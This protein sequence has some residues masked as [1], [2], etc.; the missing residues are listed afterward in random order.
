MMFLTGCGLPESAVDPET[1]EVVEQLAEATNPVISV[2]GASPIPEQAQPDDPGRNEGV[3]E[4]D[5][6]AKAEALSRGQL[7]QAFR[8]TPPEKKLPKA[9]PSSPAGGGVGPS[10]KGGVTP[11]NPDP[12]AE[13]DRFLERMEQANI[14]F[15]TPETMTRGVS[16]TFQL[17]LHPTLSKEELESRLAK[18]TGIDSAEVRIAPIMQA[19]LKGAGFT[20][21]AVSPDT[22]PIGRSEPTE[23]TWDVMPDQPGRQRLFLT[24]N[25]VFSSHGAEQ[26]RLIKSFDREIE[27]RVT[28]GEKALRVARATAA[29]TLPVILFGVGYTLYRRRTRTKIHDNQTLKVPRP[30]DLADQATVTVA[31]V[32]KP[33]FAN[34]Q[35]GHM[36]LGRYRVVKSLGAGGTAMVYRCRD[37][38]SGIDVAVKGI[39]PELAGNAPEM[40]EFRKNFQL[41]EKLHHPQIAASKTLEWDAEINAFYLIMEFVDGRTLR[42][43]FQEA[44][45]SM[46]SDEFF[47]LFGQVAAALDYAHGEG[48]M[49]RDIKPDNIMVTSEGKVKL[50]DFGVAGQIRTAMTRLTSISYQTSGTLAYMA[51]EQWKG[52]FQN[53]ATDQ[54]ALAVTIYQVLAGHCPFVN[55]EPA[56]L[57][58]IVLNE[59][60]GQPESL[61]D[62]AWA[63][64][65]RALAKQPEDRFPSCG[66]F[67]QR[68]YQ[69]CKG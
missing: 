53:A 1:D 34:L 38:V 56:A 41:I 48:I 65:H 60:P 25:A 26:T 28:A 57:R 31:V 5:D 49:H 19:T 14:A 64:L 67:I 40:E 3:L 4:N 7:D 16:Q 36:L 69:A 66:E 58:E 30:A 21:T 44:E 35:A 51:P 63:I 46:H 27:V 2:D 23:W 22:Q 47:E 17:L 62:T 59:E 12:M 55:A 68:L 32:G 42:R 43:F 45:D 6:G 61:D 24:L 54:Y 9:I 37:E 13:V 50:L 10:L 11:A 15:H 8:Q 29:W 39:P 52:A 33:S 20:I 18:A